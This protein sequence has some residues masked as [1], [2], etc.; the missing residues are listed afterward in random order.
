MFNYHDIIII[1]SEASFWAAV[2]LL[3]MLLTFVY[4]VINRICEAFE[5]KPVEEEIIDEENDE[6][7]DEDEE[8]KVS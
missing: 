5:E 1:N 6:D 3:S 8:G 2:I 4:N 7:E